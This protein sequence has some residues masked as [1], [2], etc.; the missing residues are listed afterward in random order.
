MSEHKNPAPKNEEKSREAARQKIPALLLAVLMLGTVAQIG[1]VVLL[2]E[3]LMVFHGNELSIGLILAAWLFWVGVGSRLG[4]VVSERINRPL[5]LLMFSTA[6]LLLILPAAV[7]LVRV[8]R[9]FFPVLPGGYLSLLDMT[10]S[11]FLLMG[12][13]CL[14]LGLQFVLLSRVWREKKRAEDTSGAEKT[15]IGEAAGNMLGGILFTFFMVHYLNSL[16]AVVIAGMLMLLTVL[17]MARQAAVGREHLITVPRLALLGLFVL[18]LFAFPFLED[19]DDWAYR[20]QW[21][22]FAPQHQLLETYQSE[23]GAI[24]VAQRADQYSF[25]QSGHLIF[26]TAGPETKIPGLEEQEAVEFAHLAMVQHENPG[27]VLLIGGG[28]R[29]TL[30]EILKHPVEKVDYVERDEVLTETARQY[31]S[32]GT[33]AALDDPRVHLLHG[34]G[35]LFVKTTREKY[36]LIIVDT[37]DPFTAELN[38]YYTEDFFLEAKNLLHPGGVF[39]TGTTSTPDLRGTAIANRNTTIYHT[40]ARVFS[41]VLPAG[42][43]FMFY[44]ATDAPGQISIDASTLAER[45]RARAIAAEGFSPLRYQTLLEETQLRRVNWVVRNHGRSRDG[46]LEGPGAVPPFPGTISEQEKEERKL[47]P[48]I[49]R[50]FINSDF[51][52]IGYFYTLMF[53]EE[54][55]RE[56]RRFSLQQLLHV[57]S[58]WILSIVGL[59]LLAMLG[60]RITARR[61]GRRSDT[62]FA[63]L[64][65]VFTTGLATMALQVALLF[66]FQSIYGFVYEIVGLITAMFMSGLALGAFFTH[67]Y[68]AHK[69]NIKTLAAVQLM[70]ALLAVLIAVML[71]Q[72][73]AAASPV[74]VFVLFSTLTFGAGMINGIDF[75][76]AAACYMVLSRRAERSA[77][78]VYGVELCGA[79]LGAILASALVAPVLGITACFFLAAIANGTAFVVL[80]L[81]GRSMVCLKED[82]CTAD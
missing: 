69:A 38:R 77:G 15:Y 50:Y 73:A 31:V 66:S 8:L 52:P 56:D 71:P 75:P 40:L 6:A 10:I 35:R 14:L 27:R 54:L 53:W 7:L 44:F 16:Q 57:E 26:S 48:V 49:E 34:D 60:L 64:F 70:M 23:H 47:A 58:W 13:A 37:P 59:P 22:Y 39:V 76:L 62:Y 19:V 17:L 67:R 5:L 82:Q 33:V 61:A 79:C 25:F 29:G 11:C 74:I 68:V 51:K 18:A 1:Q 4:A 78:T 45:Y 55:T 42:E 72:A 32:T 43:R 9:G 41:Q 24:S 81:C 63:L 80:L 20:L 21:S 12:P 36:D 65:T 30:G 3:F 2:R 46:H 28:L